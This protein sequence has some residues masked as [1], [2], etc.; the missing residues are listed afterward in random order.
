M[1][2]KLK[3]LVQAN[4]HKHIV[5]Y[6]IMAFFVVGIELLVFA[7]MNSILGI[8]YLIATPTSMCVAFVLNWYLSKVF[9]F[10]GSRHKTHVEFSL[11][12][13]TS[14]VGVGI[15]LL[16]TGFCINQLQLFP[17]VGKFFAVIITFFWNFW[18]RKKYIFTV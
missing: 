11:V 14:L 6:F 13:A 3:E 17:I 8:T 18:V 7:F 12:L 16:V 5:R 2:P 10:S 15:Q 1:I 9:V 4:R